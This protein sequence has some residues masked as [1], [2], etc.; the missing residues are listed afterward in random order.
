MCFRL[1]FQPMFTPDTPHIIS[2]IYDIIASVESACAGRVPLQPRQGTGE[3]AL[4]FMDAAG[5]PFLYFGAWYEL[6]SRSG[7]PLWYG[8]HEQWDGATVQRFVERH[9]E[10]VIFESFRLCRMDCAAVFEDGPAEPVVECVK[11]EIA[12][13][14]RT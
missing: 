9:P 3:R 12:C 10:A 7:F 5:Q 1:Q 14:R 4:V 13:L 6:W 2:R 11:Q 8:V